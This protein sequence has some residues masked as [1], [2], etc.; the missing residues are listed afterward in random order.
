[1]TTGRINQVTI[2]HPL[3]KEQADNRFANGDES[4]ISCEMLLTYSGPA[5]AESE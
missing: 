5:F 4:P 2:V 3:P 1:M